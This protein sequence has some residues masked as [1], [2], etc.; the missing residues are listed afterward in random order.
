MKFQMLIT[1]GHR[2]IASCISNYKIAAI[3][4]PFSKRVTV[5]FEY[6]LFLFSFPLLFTSVYMCPLV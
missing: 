2:T 4:L 3:W 1:V 5:Q 6:K